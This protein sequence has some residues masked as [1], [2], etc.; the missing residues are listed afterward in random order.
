L[1]YLLVR[2]FKIYDP[3]CIGKRVWRILRTLTFLPL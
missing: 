1:P 2:V 3:W